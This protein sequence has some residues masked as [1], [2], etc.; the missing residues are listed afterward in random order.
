MREEVFIHAAGTG[1]TN[2][3]L[4]SGCGGTAMGDAKYQYTNRWCYSYRW[5]SAAPFIN[6]SFGFGGA[7]WIGVI[8]Y[9]FVKPLRGTTCPNVRCAIWSRMLF[10]L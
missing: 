3:S 8:G 5:T 1:G 9:N 7:N 10:F 2:A 4:F 6:S